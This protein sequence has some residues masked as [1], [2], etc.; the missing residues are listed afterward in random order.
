MLVLRL[1]IICYIIEVIKFRDLTI[2]EILK[3]IG[4]RPW[5]LPKSNWKYYQEWNNAVFLHWEVDAKE[6]A[7]H[8]PSN[9]ELDLFKDNAWVSLVA[10]TMQNIR[11]KYLPAFLPISNF[12]EINIRTYV[13]YKNKP[14][15]YFLS[16]EGGKRI[17]CEIA[18]RVSEL[19][20]R[21]SSMKRKDA[22]YSSSN[23]DHKDS[24]SMEYLVQQSVTKKASLDYW[25][26]EKYALFQNIEGAINSYE[27]H[28]VEWPTNNIELKSFSVN[29][30]RFKNLINTQP[31]K[32]HL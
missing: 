19:P 1:P 31:N 20:Y 7:T 6:L 32:M 22:Y 3:T 17:S 27:I 21:Y 18:K 24:F 16:I 29:Y 23:D 25:L 9:L 11:P 5:K 14:G 15:V 2:K 10:F 13:K 30:P 28:H 4:H 8:I 12:H 26:T